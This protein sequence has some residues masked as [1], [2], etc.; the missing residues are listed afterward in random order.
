[1]ISAAL[2][3][4]LVGILATTMISSNE[5]QAYSERLRRV[6]EVNQDLLATM[7]QDLLSSVRVL[8]NDTEGT[9]YQNQLDLSG[10]PVPIDTL[11]L[12]TVD[13]TGI[14]EQE[15]ASGIKT[16]NCLLLA[17]YDSHTDFTCTSGRSYRID[18]FR[19]YYYYL[20]R[21]DRGPMPGSFTGIDLCRFV[22]EPLVN[23]HQIDQIV[24]PV[25]RSE[26]L[27][28][29][30]NATPDMNGVT[31]EPVELVW[32]R[33]GGLSEVGTLR[34][35]DSGTGALSVTPLGSRTSPWTILGDPRYSGAGLLY[36]R[37]LNVATN[38]ARDNIG[39]GRFG[40]IDNRNDGFPHGFEVQV[41]G[42]SYARKVLLHLSLVTTNRKGTK[43]HSEISTEVFLRN[44]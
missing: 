2:I 23:G 24:D 16:G 11:T 43:A 25:D 27:L 30:V 18:I 31:H 7:Q 44:Y 19:I 5:S 10:M 6:T 32:R 37:H 1:M 36:G 35:I 9:E 41:V 20:S 33:R 21:S 12:A 3:V 13:V 17:K 28:H 22:S 29:M 34:Q 38:Y 14:F 15:T 39:V 26:V 8:I 42:P 40:L 4:G